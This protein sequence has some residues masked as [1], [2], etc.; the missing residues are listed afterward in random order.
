LLSRSLSIKLKLSIASDGR[1]TNVEHTS[2][3][4]TDSFVTRLVTQSARTWRY[5]P[6][7]VNGRPVPSEQ[8]V[9]LEFGGTDNGTPAR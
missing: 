7:R 5:E 9:H 6:A 1:I 8:V 2:A 4:G 3:P